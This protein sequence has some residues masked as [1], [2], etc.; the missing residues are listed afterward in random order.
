M[1]IERITTP[2]ADLPLHSVASTRALEADASASLPPHTLMRR[3]GAA[4][5]RLALALAPHAQHVRIYAGPG[6][7]GGDGFEAAAQLRAA[8]RAVEV[9]FDGDA[10]RLPGDAA[11]SLE[12]AR[13]AGV[14]VAARARGPLAVHD[15][16]ID[17]LLGIG[18]RRAPEG[19]LAEAVAELAALPC[20]V[21][22]VD[23][24]SGLDADT[25]RPFGAACV[26]AEHTLA[27]LTLKPGLFTASGRDHAGSVWLDRLGTG[28]GDAA[29]LAWLAGA[30]HAVP[31][32]R[33]HVQ[34]KGSFGDVAVVGGAA[35]MTGAALL[36]AR[37]AHAAGAGRVYLQTLGD[38]LAFDPARPELMVR[39]QWSASA[40]DVLGAATVVCG[41]GGGA[42][43]VAVLP[44]LLSLVPRLVLDADALN[45]IAAD[46]AL[47]TLLRARAGRGH[48]TVLTPHPLEA[49]RLL[50]CAA[51][52][53]QADR[54]A[55]ARRLAEQHGCV[56]LLK[57]SGSVIAAPQRPPWINPT[58]SAALASAG[59]GDV[60]AGWIGGLWAQA[61][62][63]EP[64][65]AQRATLAAAW[66]HGR[67]G[68]RH[69]GRVLRA[70]D[71]VEAMA[72]LR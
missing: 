27:L 22:A 3:A 31:P 66:Q 67:A 18:A 15:L 8:G 5:A 40:P 6:N 7:N 68:E 57:G 16:A 63:D 28:P 29:P 1:P 55:T 11:A 37:A 44:R 49:G 62:A 51:A 71:L 32:P 26:R 20:P 41:C 39:P 30:R 23:L 65:A 50:G 34:H 59:T 56:V 46:S 19:A 9:V 21:L 25:G 17:A 52:E 45:A 24:P 4:T 72:A 61:H 38:T 12:R 13:A 54:L 36:A 35:G 42:A 47:Q 53:V 43:V 60:L 10:A 64:E 48:A 69:G 70:A 58:G 2:D 33:L 14:A